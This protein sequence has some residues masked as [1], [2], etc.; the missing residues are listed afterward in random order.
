MRFITLALLFLAIL[1]NIVLAVV[2]A[3]QLPAVDLVEERGKLPLDDEDDWSIVED[4]QWHGGHHGNHDNHGNY[5][6]WQNGP[7]DYRECPRE[8]PVSE[9]GPYQ[10][11]YEFKKYSVV[12]LLLE[13]GPSHYLEVSTEIYSNIQLNIELQCSFPYL[14]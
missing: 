1:V 5:W 3:K 11:E 9:K 2:P 8:F 7:E 14:Q 6:S 10:V 12:P 13:K 4:D